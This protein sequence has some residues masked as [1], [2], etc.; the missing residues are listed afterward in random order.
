MSDQIANKV[1]EYIDAMA[2]KLGVATEYVFNL[3]VQQKIIEGI[4]YSIVLI[5]ASVVIGIAAYKIIKYVTSNWD[6]LYRNDTEFGWSIFAA[7]IGIIAVILFIVD[8]T[9]LPNYV[10]QI[11]NPQYYAIKEILDTLKPSS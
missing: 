7:I 3:L 6:E 10:M 4:V 1:F 2:Q 5:I 8:L 11:F 9:V